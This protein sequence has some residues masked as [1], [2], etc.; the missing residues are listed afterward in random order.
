[1][2]VHIHAQILV[3]YQWSCVSTIAIWWAT[4]VFAAAQ[5]TVIFRNLL[6]GEFN[7]ADFGAFMSAVTKW[8]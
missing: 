3:L 2:H 1:M 8:L 6:D 7:W 4:C 5:E